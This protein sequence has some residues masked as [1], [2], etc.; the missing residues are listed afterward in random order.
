MS[1]PRV[2]PITESTVRSAYLGVFEECLGLAIRKSQ[3]YGDPNPAKMTYFPFGDPSYVHMLYTKCQ[4]LVSL[5]RQAMLHD[6]DPNFESL[7]DTLKDLINYAFFFAVY[8][9]IG[10]TPLI[11]AIAKTYQEKAESPHV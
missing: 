1:D 3:D 5:T 11:E 10:Q 6:K 8:R 9:G 4:R 2:N 7:D